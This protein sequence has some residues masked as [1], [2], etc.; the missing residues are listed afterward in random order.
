MEKIYS[1]IDLKNRRGS[2]LTMISPGLTI[3][4]GVMTPTFIAKHEEVFYHC[5]ADSTPRQ[6]KENLTKRLAN[7]AVQ[8]MKRHGDWEWEMKDDI[9]NLLGQLA[10][11]DDPEMRPFLRIFK[12]YYGPF[13][14]GRE[15]DIPE[16]AH[17]LKMDEKKVCHELDE[18]STRYFRKIHP[19]NIDYVGPLRRECDRQKQH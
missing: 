11:G 1:F 2:Y 16:I 4:K 12:M 8:N 10:G 6:D 18:M 5:L 7:V 17:R 15:Y 9:S 3:K 13:F 14:R 19:T